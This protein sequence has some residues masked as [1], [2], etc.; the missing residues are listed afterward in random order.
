MNTVESGIRRKSIWR[1]LRS[2]DLNTPRALAI[3]RVAV[4]L[5]FGLWSLWLGQDRN[6]DLFNYHLYNAFAFLHD[7]LQTDFAPAGMQTYFNPVLDVGYYLLNA[8]LP[9]PLVGFLMGVIHGLNFVLLLSIA[10]RAL[11]DLPAEDRYRVPLLLAVAGVLTA[12]FLSELGNT[13]GDDTTALFSL[14]SLLVLLT[15]WHGLGCGAAKSFGIAV[16]GGLLVGLGMGLKLTNV[17]YA[18]ALCASLLLF[19]ATPFARVRLAFLFG[20][21][22]LVGLSLTGGYWLWKMWETFGNPVFPQ[23]SSVFPNAL[24]PRVGVADTSWLPKTVLQTVLWPLLFSLDSRRI[25][26]VTIHQWIWP[27]VYV[28]FWAWAIISGLRILRSSSRG[29][30]L[31]PRARCV[32]AF[33]ALS[34]L[35][36]LKLFSIYRY[37]VPMELL[38]PVVAFVLLTQLTSYLTARRIAVWTLSATT[39]VVVLGGVE[40]WGHESWASPAFRAETPSLDSPQTTTAIIV[41]DDPAWGWLATLFPYTVAFTQ[42]GGNFPATPLYDEHVREMVR[43]RG[44]P[45]F[46]VFQVKYNW[47]VEFVAKLN[48]IA[49]EIGF[50]GSTQACNR[51]Q[52][53]VSR[54][55]LHASVRWLSSASQGPACQLGLRADDVHDPTAENQR[56]VEQARTIL[57]QHGFLIDRLKCSIHRAQVGQGIYPYQWCRVTLR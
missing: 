16:L 42:I 47:R 50:T 32:V 20:V 35:L 55:R 23:F 53:T 43:Q 4:P 25:G 38:T 54:L 1:R 8:Y 40:T 44:G 30:A 15:Y 56:S 37:V 51:L 34:Y 11:P 24:T 46:A 28:L 26:Q 27:V 41:G 48:R 3:A 17:I 2:V 9:A 33:V 21:G 31:D 19:P 36:W 6:W 22:V 49:N 13:M 39:L 18:V 10:R 5:L 12:N 14:A 7:K 45:A 52:W 57:E 29:K